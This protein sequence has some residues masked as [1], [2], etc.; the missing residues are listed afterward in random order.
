[1]KGKLRI[2]LILGI[3]ATHLISQAQSRAADFMYSD[4]DNNSAD[5]EPP[6]RMSPARLERIKE[7]Y[8]NFKTSDHNVFKI[9]EERNECE[10]GGKWTE[11][12]GE[13]IC[14]PKVPR[15]RTPRPPRTRRPG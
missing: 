12:A 2:C 13:I 6:R 14:V 4:E 5:F 1:M 10:G 9:V 11:V 15:T 8:P 7:R 3:L